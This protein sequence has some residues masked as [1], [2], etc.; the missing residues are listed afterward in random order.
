MVTEC[1][2]TASCAGMC[3]MYMCICTM[4]ILC[5]HIH[6]LLGV[7]AFACCIIALYM[8]IFYMKLMYSTC[9][10][11]PRWTQQLTDEQLRELEG[12]ERSNVEARIALLRNVQQLLDAAVGQLNQ[13]SAV[14]ATLG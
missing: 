3:G 9:T 11:Q 2:Y 7:Q 12:M 1:V 8:E 10:G 5:V 14:M 4:Y 13:Y 6:V